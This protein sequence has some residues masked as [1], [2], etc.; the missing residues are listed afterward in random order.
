MKV[1]TSTARNDATSN[2][3]ANRAPTRHM[4]SMFRAVPL[5]SAAAFCQSAGPPGR[6]RGQMSPQDQADVAQIE[7][8]LNG[9]KSLKARFTQVAGDGGVSQGTAWLERPG[10]M[11]FQYDPPAPFLLIA[12]HGQLIFHDSVAW[13]DQQHPFEPHTA[14]HPAGGS[15][16]RFPARLR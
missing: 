9:V 3:F 13:A 4:A 12:A 16:R 14:R 8:Y 11:R 1:A 7:T 10:R 6:P 15:C 2:G 5:L